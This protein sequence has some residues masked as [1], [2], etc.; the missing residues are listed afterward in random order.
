MPL[1]QDL[2]KTSQGSTCAQ[3]MFFPFVAFHRLMAYRAK[4]RGISVASGVQKCRARQCLRGFR[5]M[6]TGF[7]K[8]AQVSSSHKLRVKPQLRLLS[9]K[10]KLFGRRAVTHS[11]LNQRNA[12]Q[13]SKID[14][15]GRPSL[16]YDGYHAG[17][18]GRLWRFI[19]MSFQS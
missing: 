15:L 17:A 10:S 2:V 16:R 5:H 11:N 19:G 12:L 18:G 9:L 6:F 14:H 3:M 7:T 1:R 4:S 8:R 13:T